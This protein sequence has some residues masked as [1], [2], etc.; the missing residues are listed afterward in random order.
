M[1]GREEGVV[2]APQRLS[3][4]TR[5]PIELRVPGQLGGEP[6]DGERGAIDLEEALLDPDAVV[7][8]A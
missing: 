4:G 5:E 1:D 7:L 2:G 8:D 6:V 3:V